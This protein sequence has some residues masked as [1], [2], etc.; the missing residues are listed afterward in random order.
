MLGVKMALGAAVVVAAVGAAAAALAAD[1]DT[2]AI[3]V[4]LLVTQAGIAAALWGPRRLVTL[5]ADLA[6]WATQRASV[7]GEPLAG[8]VDR[9]VAAYRD[10]LTGRDD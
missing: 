1:W 6:R 8:I 4:A 3:L 7:T 5:R 9:S 10:G 2:F